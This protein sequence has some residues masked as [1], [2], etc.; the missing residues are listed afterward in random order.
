MQATAGA[1][2]QTSGRKHCPNPAKLRPQGR[3]G[4]PPSRRPRPSRPPGPEGRP[5]SALLSAMEPAVRDPRW[6]CQKVPAGSAPEGG[7]ASGQGRDLD[8]GSAPGEKRAGPGNVSGRTLG[9]A[10]CGVW[11][12]GGR[13]ARVRSKRPKRGKRAER[14]GAGPPA[15]SQSGT[16]SCAGAGENARES[17]QAA[18]GRDSW[19]T[20][21]GSLPSASHQPEAKQQ[22]VI[23]T[24]KREVLLVRAK[25]VPALATS[26]HSRAH[27]KAQ[28]HLYC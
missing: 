25:Q 2:S 22:R 5:V 18:A 20:A 19:E 4:W 6:S 14:T 13:E 26:P 15:R 28:R 11:A 23:C 7:A 16:W 9:L 24:P 27:P 10:R 8:P 12:A 17:H 21:P 3:P 1:S